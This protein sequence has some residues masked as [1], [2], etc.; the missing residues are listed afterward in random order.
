M[1]SLSRC[2]ILSSQFKSVFT[3]DVY[4][5]LRDTTLFGPSY[6]PIDRLIIREKRIRKLLSGIN[7]SKASDLDHIPC[8]LLK[9]LSNQLSPIYLHAYSSS[10][11]LQ[12]SCPHFGIKKGRRNLTEN[13]SPASLTCVVCKLMEHIVSSHIRSHLYEYGVLT[14]FTGNH[15]FSAGCSCESQLLL[16][17]HDMYHKLD[18]C[19]QVDVAVFDFSKAFDTVPHQ[20]LLWKLG[21]C[22]IN[23]NIH[24]WISQFLSHRTQSLMVEGV[25]SREDSIDLGWTAQ[26]QGILREWLWQV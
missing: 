1:G 14:P 11:W 5:P 25:R 6:P 17:T 10:P 12:G 7:P 21:H 19:N 3:K 4:D 22:G 13:Y 26:S 18:Q 9:E 16:T 2:E 8:R 20:R 15:G 24:K 23:E